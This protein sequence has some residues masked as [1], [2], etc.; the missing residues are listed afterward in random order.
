MIT[1]VRSLVFA[2][3][4]QAEVLSF[5][6]LARK[7]LSEKHGIEMRALVQVGGDPM[8]LDYAATFTSLAEFEQAYLK[9]LAD[10]EYLKLTAAYFPHIVVGSIRDQLW[11]DI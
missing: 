4:K 10:A 3:G 5:T 6:R 1:F 2:P 7:L 11:R 8:R 9:L